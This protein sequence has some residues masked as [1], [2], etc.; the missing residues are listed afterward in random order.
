MVLWLLYE[1]SWLYLKAVGPVKKGKCSGGS[2]HYIIYYENI[3]FLYF[4]LKRT[5]DHEATGI[6]GKYWVLQSFGFSM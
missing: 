6:L 4:Y 3:L 1:W 2:N 5:Y